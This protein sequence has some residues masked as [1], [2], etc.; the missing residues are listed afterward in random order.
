MSHFEFD[1]IVKIGSMALLREKDN[2]L[3][4]NIFSRLGYDLKPGM[5]LVT[6]GAAEIGRIDYMRR[7][8]GRELRGDKEDIK[9]DYSAQGQSILMEMYRRFI[10]T[11][12]SIR[13]V[14]V[15]HSH[16]NDPEKAE[17]IRHLL[18]RAANQNAIPIV[19]YNDAVSSE[20]NRKF[21]I[22]TLMQNGDGGHIAECVDNDETAAVITKLV[23]AEK[24]ILLTS[25]EGIYRDPSDPSTLIETVVGSSPEDINAKID[26]MIRYCNGTSRNGSNGASAKL[27]FAKEALSM[28]TTVMIAHARHRL[29]DIMSG[30]IPCTVLR[31][32]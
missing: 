24:L 18:Y 31:V 20:E 27:Q 25:T 19:N 14:L 26:K 28:G 32:E 22:R 21:E 1:A 29:R 2:D 16:M 5:I 7:N 8:G 6:S 12:Y 23:G 13:Q 30:K 15:E 10:P 4:Y 17:H 9:T 11:E 3:D